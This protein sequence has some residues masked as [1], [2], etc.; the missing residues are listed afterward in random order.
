M[1]LMQVHAARLNT[2]KQPLEVLPANGLYLDRCQVDTPSELVKRVW[3]LL[4]ERRAHF[5]T[6]VDFGAGDGRF[7]LHGSYGSYSGYEIDKSRYK[8]TKLPANA[9]I[10]N[11]CAFSENVSDASL[12]LGNPPYVRNQDLPAGWRE[13]AARTIEAR[14]GFRVPGL[15]NAW[16]YFFMHSLASTG[17]QGIV[18]LVIPFEWVS[19]P[20]VAALREYIKAQGWSVT[21]YRLD[22]ST[23]DRVLTTASITIVD[24]SRKDGKWEFLKERSDGTFARMRGPS[25]GRRRVLG[26]AAPGEHQAIRAKR[27]LSPG[28]QEYLT[29]TERERARCGLKPG[30]DVIP[31]VTSLRHSAAAGAVLDAKGFQ[32]DF[33]D[34]GKKCWLIRTDKAPGKRLSDYLESVPISGRQSATCT[35]RLVWWKFAMPSI[36]A[37]LLASGFR[38]RPKALVNAVGAAA[39]GSVCGIYGV[40]A[41]NVRA[42]VDGLRGVDYSGRVV[43]HSHGLRKLEINQMNEL[44]KG[45]LEKRP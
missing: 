17:G 11:V 16:Q 10:K 22:D 25:G 23:F 44:I 32:R 42:L 15:A 45:I 13:L 12:C 33:I 39:V 21:T 41:K 38:E 4:T 6:V 43:A 19:R 7:A 37:I 20:S 29:L 1:G 27:G 35:G 36:P 26:Y 34:A 9:S 8:A 40:G 30:V 24:K 5:D 14:T 28:T 3:A 31:C 18:A 2:I